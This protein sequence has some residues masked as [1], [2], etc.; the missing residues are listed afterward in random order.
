MPG[1]DLLS[2]FNSQSSSICFSIKGIFLMRAIVAAYSALSMRP[3]SREVPQDIIKKDM[4]FK[5]RKNF[6]KILY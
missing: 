3:S 1:S 2:G 6:I 5:C 4:K